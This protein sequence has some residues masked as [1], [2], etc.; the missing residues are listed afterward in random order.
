MIQPSCPNQS[1]PQLCQAYR[2]TNSLRYASS[3]ALALLFVG[4]LNQWN[5]LGWRL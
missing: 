3:L 4:S 2:L 1:I 5:L